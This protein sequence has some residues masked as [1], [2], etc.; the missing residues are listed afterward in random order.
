MGSKPPTLGEMLGKLIFVLM[1]NEGD[2]PLSNEA[3]PKRLVAELLRFAKFKA[4]E[5]SEK[6]Y[7]VDPNMS[8]DD[9]TIPYFRERFFPSIS[10]SL[11]RML[12][13]SFAFFNGWKLSVTFSFASESF[14]FS[15]RSVGLLLESI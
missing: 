10:S 5:E 2:N 7:P 3:F 13:N 6:S 9:D 15:F 4:G 11:L 12:T 8:T 14:D 1:I